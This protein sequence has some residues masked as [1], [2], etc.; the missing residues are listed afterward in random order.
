M[1]RS[2]NPKVNQSEKFDINSSL[3]SSIKRKYLITIIA[4]IIL[5]VLTISLKS[6]KVNTNVWSFSLELEVTS[7]TLI[8]VFLLWHPAL[9]PWFL[10][11]F[12]QLRGSVNW[13]REQ[14][15]E[16]ADAF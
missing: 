14:G 7:I 9:L 4:L 5:S 3:P 1:N 13:L 11:Q 6:D 8:L 16:A 10:S 15:I 12:A 2:S